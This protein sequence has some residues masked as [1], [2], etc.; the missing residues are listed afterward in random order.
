MTGANRLLMGFGW[1]LIFFVAA[2][3]AWRKG[4]KFSEIR[5]EKHQSVEIMF[6]LAATIYSLVIIFF[7]RIS[8]IESFVLIVIY[9]IYI[10][11]ILQL[12]PEVGHCDAPQTT[13]KNSFV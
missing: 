7:R 13:E 12:P 5:L 6:L 9:T 3:S 11:I 2:F 1:P 10:F 8:L 4:V